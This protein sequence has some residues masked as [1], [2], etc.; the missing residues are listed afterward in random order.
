MTAQTDTFQSLLS[1][2][3]LDDQLKQTSK[4]DNTKEHIETVTQHPI[5]NQIDE[6]ITN[7]FEVF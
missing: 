6:K 4:Q 7:R 2:E 5:T 3:I 1:P